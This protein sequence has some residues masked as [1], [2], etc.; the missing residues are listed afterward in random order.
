MFHRNFLCFSP[1]TTLHG[2]TVDGG[3][4]CVRVVLQATRRAALTDCHRTT[5]GA[6]GKSNSGP[7]AEGRV[8]CPLSCLSGWSQKLLI[9]S[10]FET[11]WMDCADWSG[12]LVLENQF[13]DIPFE[14]T[15]TIIA[16]GINCCSLKAALCVISYKPSVVRIPVS[17]CKVSVSIPT[18]KEVG[19][20]NHRILNSYQPVT[21]VA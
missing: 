8:L 5:C 11:G 21:L 17:H 15:T 1:T 19:S 18:G 10:Y 7:R 6:R 14:I 16:M 12:P 2:S 4:S 20:P 3:R 9:L 13:S